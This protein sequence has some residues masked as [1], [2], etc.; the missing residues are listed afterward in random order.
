MSQREVTGRGF[1]LVEAMRRCADE[2]ANFQLSEDS[3]MVPDFTLAACM[4]KPALELSVD[5]NGYI[6]RA[7]V[8]AEGA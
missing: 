3:T 1:T 2:V 8:V 6:V 5:A 4:S 7:L